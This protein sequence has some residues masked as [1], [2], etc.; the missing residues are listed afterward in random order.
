MQPLSRRATVVVHQRRAAVPRQGGA[1][2]LFPAAIIPANCRLHRERDLLSAKLSGQHVHRH[3]Q[4]VTSSPP[5]KPMLPNHQRFFPNCG[6]Q[7]QNCSQKLL[8]MNRPA[9]EELHSLL[10]SHCHC[11]ASIVSSPGRSAN[12]AGGRGC[13]T[14][15]VGVGVLV[16]IS[17]SWGVVPFWIQVPAVGGYVTPKAA[18]NAKPGT[19]ARCRRACRSPSYQQVGVQPSITSGQNQKMNSTFADS[20]AQAEKEI[21]LRLFGHG[22]RRDEG[23]SEYM[24]S[25]EWAAPG[26]S[27][28][29]VHGQCRMGSA[30]TKRRRSTW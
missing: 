4:T 3:Y 7:F 9:E 30:G 5:D 27:V 2:P 25:A 8:Q 19:R 1:A 29:G 26:R 20:L 17:V 28:V 15:R 11:Q 22:Q 10:P 6:T 21:F 12:D 24:G 16:T 13:L 14:R 18:G 23:S